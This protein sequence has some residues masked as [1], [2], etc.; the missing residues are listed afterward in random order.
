MQRRLVDEL[1]GGG[2]HIALRNARDDCQSEAAAR[3]YGGIVHPAIGGTASA[4][5][6]RASTGWRQVNNGAVEVRLV[7]DLK[8]PVEVALANVPHRNGEATVHRA[9]AAHAF[10]VLFRQDEIGLKPR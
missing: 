2:C 3:R 7:S 1:A 8:R 10:F 9:S 5:C 6:G 4:A